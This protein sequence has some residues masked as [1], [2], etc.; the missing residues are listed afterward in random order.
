M[1]KFTVGERLRYERQRMGLTQEELARAMSVTKNCI[2][3]WEH[4]RTM[5]DILILDKLAEIFGI[6]IKDFLL[7]PDSTAVA[8]KRSAY[9][10]NTDAP[11]VLS[12]KE[13]SVINKLRHMPHD[14][15]KA[16]EVLLGVRGVPEQI[17]K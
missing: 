11:I 8:E 16:F 2:G 10:S 5:P 12:D 9:G 6:E 7:E 1:S 17:A 15:R 14:R 4:S 13:L 3:S